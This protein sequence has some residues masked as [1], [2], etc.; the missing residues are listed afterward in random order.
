MHF[1]L[2]NRQYPATIVDCTMHKAFS[3]DRTTA[4]TPRTCAANDRILFI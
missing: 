4:L 3:T 1:F 2:I